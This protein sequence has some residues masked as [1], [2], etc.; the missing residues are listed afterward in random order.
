[1][2]THLIAVTLF[3]GFL[4]SEVSSQGTILDQARDVPEQTEKKQHAPANVFSKLS[5]SFPED[6]KD[7]KPL[8]YN[9]FV[10]APGKS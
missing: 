7:L 2:K 9:L 8:T 10:R 3:I 4:L 5:T 1:M 6:D